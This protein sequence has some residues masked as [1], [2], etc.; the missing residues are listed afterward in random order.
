MLRARVDPPRETLWSAHTASIP[1]PGTDN[2]VRWTDPAMRTRL[3]SRHGRSHALIAIA[4]SVSGENWT[5]SEHRVGPASERD[6]GRQAGREP[7]PDWTSGEYS[8]RRNSQ[9]RNSQRR[10][11]QFAVRSSQRRGSQRH[12]APRGA[13][14]SCGTSVSRHYYAVWI[15]APAGSRPTRT[16]SV[17]DR[18]F[19]G[20]ALPCTFRGSPH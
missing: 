18:F 5:M 13:F 20:R 16:E 14:R 10:G 12:M 1:V 6:T 19:I 17:V 9:R 15:P 4:A 8:Q 11:S 3:S 2:P 7:Q